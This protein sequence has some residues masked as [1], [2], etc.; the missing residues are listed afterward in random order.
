MQNILGTQASSSMS[1][2]DSSLGASSPSAAVSAS[3]IAGNF[4]GS[5]Q[6][7]SPLE[8]MQMSADSSPSAAQ[9]VGNQ[10]LNAMQ[11]QHQHQQPQSNFF[12]QSPLM[13]AAQDVL[14]QQQQNHQ[15]RIGSGFSRRSADLQQQKA[16]HHRVNLNLNDNNQ[17]HLGQLASVA[18]EPVSQAADGPVTLF[19]GDQLEGR[20]S[21]GAA[22]WITLRAQSSA[23]AK[24]SSSSE[25]LGVA[26]SAK[27][28]SQLISK[29]SKFLQDLLQ[30]AN[31]QSTQQATSKRRHDETKLIALND[32]HRYS[33]IADELDS[34]GSKLSPAQNSLLSAVSHIIGLN[35]SPKQ[36]A[37]GS[38]ESGLLNK[39]I[40]H[41]LE[42]L[43]QAQAQTSSSSQQ[44]S[45]VSGQPEQRDLSHLLP[46]TWKE[47]VKRTYN[48]VQH[49]ASNQWRSIEGQITGWLKPA[50]A[51]APAYHL[52]GSTPTS[53]A[54]NHFHTATS[55][56]AAGP[57]TGFLQSAV[58]MLG[59]GAKQQVASAQTQP[60]GSSTQTVAAATGPSASAP[61]DVSSSKQPA[62]K[63]GGLAAVA[64]IILNSI[65]GSK[66]TQQTG[67]NN[68]VNSPSTASG[69]SSSSKTPSA[70]VSVAPPPAA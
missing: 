20:S 55:G 34:S 62:A 25:T 43:P 35:S 47:A 31:R 18:A 1:P 68:P 38:S 28:V 29:S 70:A 23:Q 46:Q 51:A 17:D 6:A 36:E 58:N 52:A 11:Q 41:Q 21:N 69:N 42:L 57:V 60:A 59:L 61:S 27:S 37:Q 3:P 67:Q 53:N 4:L 56:P 12:L 8:P 5:L 24:S 10:L 54:H 50:A 15:Q 7:I 26:R 45:T 2:L 44:T 22:N 66:G 14:Q 16:D 13:Q 39:K 33:L 30:N 63:Q 9:L 65:T 64:S 48:N 49:S 32:K 40:S 19:A